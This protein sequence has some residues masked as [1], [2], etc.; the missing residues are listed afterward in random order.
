MAAMMGFA[1]LPRLGPDFADSSV[2]MRVRVVGLIAGLLVLALLG[3]GKRKMPI[4][5]RERSLLLRFWLFFGIAIVSS[6]I[7]N[8]DDVGSMISVIWMAA[9]IP[10]ILFDRVP[11]QLG[12]FG[13]RAVIISILLAASPYMI[14]WFISNPEMRFAYRGILINSNTPGIVSSTILISLLPV[15]MDCQRKRKRLLLAMASI[16]IVAMFLVVLLSGSRTSFM[17]CALTSLLV[18]LAAGRRFVKAWFVAAGLATAV[19]AVLVYQYS[20]AFSMF[21]EIL[22]KQQ[23]M[24]DS[25]NVLS[26]RGDIWAEVFHN[27]TFFGHGGHYFEDVIGIGP[28]NSI[29]WALGVRGPCAAMALVPIAALSTRCAWAFAKNHFA[30]DPYAVGVLALIIHFWT[31]SMTEA[32]LGSFGND[33][34]IAAFVCMGLATCQTQPRYRRSCAEARP[35]LGAR[36]LQPGASV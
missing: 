35:A 28:H 14:G 5:S 7:A 25:G 24:A 4:P 15:A 3:N 8:L 30:L 17:S 6:A 32:M 20:D 11:A 13:P 34:T 21:L 18:S 23:A 19:L 22:S 36:S 2:L 9:G 31:V 29:I 10:V 1:S 12:R 16:I 27:A 33:L 26:S